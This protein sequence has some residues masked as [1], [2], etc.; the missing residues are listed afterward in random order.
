MHC[1]GH[2]KGPLMKTQTRI[3]DNRL[4]YTRKIELHRKS[5]KSRTVRI[6]PRVI[7]PS[8]SEI[9]VLI[10]VRR[11]HHSKMGKVPTI[12]I[13]RNLFLICIYDQVM[14]FKTNI[15][16]V[17]QNTLG[18]IFNTTVLLFFYHVASFAFLVSWYI[19]F[20]GI[21]YAKASLSKNSCYHLTHSCGE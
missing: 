21:C 18:V 11:V 13:K 4:Y 14:S 5:K 1:W 10:M 17:T 8:G 3:L 19:N 2:G 15:L 9:S 6:T 20:Q 7:G 16:S 12:Y